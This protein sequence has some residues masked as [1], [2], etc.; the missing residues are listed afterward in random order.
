MCGKGVVVS[1]CRNDRIS[2]HFAVE[3]KKETITESAGRQQKKK[4]GKNGASKMVAS[5]ETDGSD[6]LFLP[7]FGLT[8]PRQEIPSLL[9]VLIKWADQWE[10]QHLLLISLTFSPILALISMAVTNSSC[11]APCCSALA[12]CSSY[13]N[14]VILDL[15]FPLH[16]NPSE[17]KVFILIVTVLRLIS[18]LIN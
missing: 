14:S 12:A 1:L 16:L 17:L 15:F 4:I 9:V 7:S 10:E 18:S 11:Q 3:K 6:Y 5:W 2:F 8:L 13:R